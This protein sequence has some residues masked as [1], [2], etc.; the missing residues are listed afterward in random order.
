MAYF[1]NIDGH[2]VAP[3]WYRF[4]RHARKAGVYFV[5][6]SGHRTMRE[7]WKLWRLY[8]AGKG[9]LAAFPSPRAPH[10]RRRNHAVDFGP[11]HK[12]REAIIAYGRRHGVNLQRTVRTEDWHLEPIGGFKHFKP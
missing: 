2:P 9:N 8:K 12:A 4:L 7:Q 3:G 11:D 6:N 5:V 10:I 1:H